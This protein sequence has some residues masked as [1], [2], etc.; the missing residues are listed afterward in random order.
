MLSTRSE[1]QGQNIRVRAVFLFLVP[2]SLPIKFGQ[3]KVK[4]FLRKTSFNFCMKMTLGQSQE[5]TL[6]L[7]THILL[8]TDLVFC[9]YLCSGHRLQEFPKNPLFSLFPI[10]KYNLTLS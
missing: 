1:Q 8:S 6:T 5:M 4:W 10:E 7:K 9:I 3:K 2:K